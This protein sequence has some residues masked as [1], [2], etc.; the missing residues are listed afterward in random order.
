[1][2][3]WS[4]L[5]AIGLLVDTCSYVNN[6]HLEILPGHHHCILP[7]LYL[8]PPVPRP[9]HDHGRGADFKILRVAAARI[10]I[11]SFTHSFIKVIREPCSLDRG[12][13]IYNSDRGTWDICAH[14]V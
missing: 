9:T 2:K 13:T 1:M 7:Q 12:P 11:I 8:P 4:Y 14:I 6:T 5:I 10:T 3:F